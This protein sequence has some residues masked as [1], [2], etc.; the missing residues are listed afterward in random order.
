MSVR[1]YRY[2]V[3]QLLVVLQSYPHVIVHGEHPRA[4]ST[5]QR[6]DA[7]PMPV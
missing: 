1:Y 3:L 6:R 4:H 7:A 5:M 2:A